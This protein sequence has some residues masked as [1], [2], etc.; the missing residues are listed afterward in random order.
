[1]PKDSARYSDV[2]LSSLQPSWLFQNS[3]APAVFGRVEV[4]PLVF[5]LNLGRQRILEHLVGKNQNCPFTKT[6]RHDSI[7]QPQKPSRRKSNI[8]RNGHCLAQSRTYRTEYPKENDSNCPESRA[9]TLFSVYTNWNDD[10]GDNEF[11]G[12]QKHPRQNCHRADL[13]TSCFRHRFRLEITCRFKSTESK[14]WQQTT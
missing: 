5:S 10:I 6:W 2:I 12:S 4:R 8:S 14:E 7:P 11:S 3:I 1:V 13:L 9:T